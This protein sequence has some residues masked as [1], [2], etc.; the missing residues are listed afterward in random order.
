MNKEKPLYFDYHATT[1]LDKRVL[2]KMMPWLTDLFYNPHA[3]TYNKG[4]FAMSAI[5]H[6]RHEI[7]SLI[8]AEKS[9][10][11]FTS[12]ATESN[13]LALKGIMEFIEDTGKDHLMV[14]QIDHK[15]ILETAK[16][17][18]RKGKKVSFIPVNADGFVDI[19]FIKNNITDKTALVSVIFA[20]NEIGVIQDVQKIGKIC[21]EKGVYFHCDAAQAFGKVDI[22]V[23]DMNIDLMSISGHKIYGPK[24][25]GALYVSKQPRVK[26]ATQV[27]GGGQER[28]FRSGTLSPALCVGL[29][30]AAQ[31]A[32]EDMHKDAKKLREYTKVFLDII[33]KNLTHVGINGSLEN[34]L[35]G[36]INISFSGVEGEGLMLSLSEDACISSGSACSS[37]NL[38]GSYVIRALGKEE[39]IIHSSQR[40]SFGRFTQKEDVEYL[41]H[42]IVEKVNELRA[43]SPVWD[44]IQ[45]GVDLKTIKWK[46]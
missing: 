5:N 15:C 18:E 38:Q 4:L 7:A 43:M 40:I 27:H 28:G 25:I 21:R 34:R 39:E 16:Y 41:A 13:N 46:E 26:L 11:I 2:E 10:V 36:S 44:L 32:S 45:K 14:S 9:E 35:A 24:G 42:R 29:G 17:L 33:N 22:D 1:P 8:G 3:S 37:Q 31:I 12:G 30:A 23:K 6:A 20:N 19:D